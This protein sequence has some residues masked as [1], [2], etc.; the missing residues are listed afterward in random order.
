MAWRAEGDDL[1]FL[2]ADGR[3]STR[4]ERSNEVDGVL[5]LHGSFVLHGMPTDQHVLESWPPYD[6]APVRSAFHARIEVARSPGRLAV[7]INSLAGM[8][9]GDE[10]HTEFEMLSLAASLDANSVRVA[11]LISR[12]GWYADKLHDV[13]AVVAS[14]IGPGTRKVAVVGTSA[15]GFGAVLVADLLARTHP[16]QRF[17]SV[18][19]NAQTSLLPALMEQVWEAAPARAMPVWIERAAR[20]A[21]DRDLL[22]LRAVVERPHGSAEHV[23]IYDS[24]NVAETLHAERMADAPRCRL[25]GEALGLRHGEGCNAFYRSGLMRHLVGEFFG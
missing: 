20:L 2:A 10:R 1:L 16:A 13:A 4:F 7:T 19:A 5:R 14:A 15:G 12:R 11:E 6:P 9:D 22:D 21:C 18:V 25:L 17:C 3:V 24:A 8:F 23:F